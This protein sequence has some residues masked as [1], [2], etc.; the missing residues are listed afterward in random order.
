MVPSPTYTSLTSVAGREGPAENR[1]DAGDQFLRRERLDHVI[2]G[3]HLQAAD[4]VV[5]AAAGGQEDDRPGRVA[6]AQFG[7]HLEAVALGEH[8][9]EQ[10]QIDAVGGRFAKPRRAVGRLGH[11][12]AAQP[13]RIRQAAANGGFILNHHDSSF[14]HDS[15]GK[16]GNGE[17]APCRD[18]P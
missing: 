13:E 7:Q 1:L 9:I 4:P 15:P 14:R 17:S 8:D 16:G 10:D 6:A 3:P 5:L 2:V 12:V 18:T 11:L